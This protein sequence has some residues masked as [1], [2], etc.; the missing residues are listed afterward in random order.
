MKP[1]LT[2]FDEWQELLQRA[3]SGDADAQLEVAMHY[4]AGLT[5]SDGCQ[6]APDTKMAY[7][8]TKRAYENGNAEAAEQYAYYVSNGIGCTKNTLL[9]MQLY[10]AAMKAGSLTAAHNLGTEFRDQHNFEQAFALYR[11]DS[12]DFATGMCYYYGIGVQ[13]NKLKA[14]RF[15]KGL[16]K[17]GSSLNGYETNEANYMIGKM[18]LEGEVVKQSVSKARHYLLLANEDGDHRSAQQILWIIGIK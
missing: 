2:R 1:T 5:T 15:F 14:F 18:Y 16:L 8:W 6:I 12:T 11:K 3:E 17:N 9:A 10:K 7:E 13:Q 4:N